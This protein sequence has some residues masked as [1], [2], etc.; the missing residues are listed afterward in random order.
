MA[1]IL[2]W[3]DEP[4]TTEYFS[5]PKNQRRFGSVQCAR[6]A[7]HR[8]SFWTAEP[9]AVLRRPDLTNREMADA[10][11]VCDGTGD[12]SSRAWVSGTVPSG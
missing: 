6:I 5:R 4:G 1:G 11:G 7:E 8:A 12:A 2:D 9:D 10:I 3:D